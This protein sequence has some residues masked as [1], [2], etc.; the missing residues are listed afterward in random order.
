M[1]LF[2]NNDYSRGAHPKVIEK[3]LETNM[4]VELGYGFD[5]YCSSEKDKIKKS[6][7]K[8]DAEIYFL[9]G[10]TQTNA[11]VIRSVL[12]QCE[13]VIAPDTGHISTH[14]AGIIEVGGHKV[15]ELK[16]YEGK[17]RAIDVNNY[18]E[19]YNKDEI[20]MHMVRP[21][22]VYITYPTEYGTLY[23]KDEL[24]E[25]YDVCKENNIPLYVDGAR[26]GYGL[27]ARECD[28]SFNEFA[29]LCDI[30]YIGGTKV[31]ALCGEAIVFSNK[32][33]VPNNFPTLIKQMGGLLA[34]GRL[35]GVQ[36]DALF[37]NDLYFKISKNAINMAHI[38]KTNLKANNYKFFINS[39]TNQQFIILENEK[40]KKLQKFINFSI[41]ED[42]DENNSVIRLVTDWSTTEEDINKVIKL[43]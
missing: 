1:T 6:C 41:W 20:K 42:Y 36:F 37:T 32:S 19:N 17:I 25:L 16:N 39:P 7:G 11:T 30:F 12:K 24:K 4:Q 10:G 29:N 40:I 18:I 21:G 15:I 35:L 31:G 3:I 14:E 22:M 27:V 33:Y 43:F 2:F 13:G 9:V 26:L 8:E 23:S 28:M 34:K 38:L 5:S